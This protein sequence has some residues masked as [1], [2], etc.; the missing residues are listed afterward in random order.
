MNKILH[1]SI[2]GRANVG[3]S[4]IINRI[5]NRKVSIVSP[6]PQTT[7]RSMYHLTHHNDVKWVIWDTPGLLE[8]KNKLDLF[9]NSEAIS[10]FKKSELII[11]IVDS[12]SNYNDQNAEIARLI[13][14]VKNLKLILIYSKS[15]L[16]E[17]QN[18]FEQLQNKIEA[19]IKFTNKFYLNLNED[20]LKQ[21]KDKLN[22]F[23]VEDDGDD[24]YLETTENDD[25]FITEI[26][27]EQII[28]NTFHEI[29]HASTVIIENK[30]YDNVKNIFHIDC[31]IVVEKDSQKAIIIGKGAS[32]IK[33][34]G[35]NARLELE[36]I[37][38]SK[39]NLKLF[40]KVEKDWRD[41]NYLIKSFGFKKWH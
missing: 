8:V 11:Y 1:F 22:E 13:N 27:R 25:F 4:T 6:I 24:I 35:M 18:K 33:Q 2:I 36:Q 39:I 28:K 9:L 38:D 30:K 20:N 7:R 31:V 21:L 15:D 29:P 37:Y 40:C 12:T 3:K 17:D 34:I 10:T 41:N 23:A 14:S 5:C 16:V 32:K 19:E 26:I